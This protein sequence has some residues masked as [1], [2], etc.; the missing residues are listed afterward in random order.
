MTFHAATQPVPWV[1]AFRASACEALTWGALASVAFAGPALA[2]EQPEAMPNPAEQ[3]EG[4][5]DE[6][7]IPQAPIIVSGAKSEQKSVILGSRIARKPLFDSLNYASSTSLSGTLGSGITPFPQGGFSRNITISKCT[8][9]SKS[10]REETACLLANADR[11]F[12]E[13]DLE[14]A[15]DTVRFVAANGEFTADERLEGAKRLYRFGEVSG[16]DAMREEAL[17]RMLATGAIAR[18]EQPSLLRSLVAMALKRDDD[19]AA[20]NRLEAVVK[21]EPADVQS[22]ANLAALKQRNGQAGAAAL[23]AQAVSILEREGKPVPESWAQLA[24]QSDLAAEHE[25]QQ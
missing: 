10:V 2:Q 7:Q 22:L 1:S 17:L 16:T 5:L 18:T 12:E 8:S 19:L 21:L 14:T 9:D 4:V 24:A 23:M 3:D 13:G 15:S 25:P 6:A 11:L 20:I